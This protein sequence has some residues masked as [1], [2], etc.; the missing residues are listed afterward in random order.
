MMFATY[1]P[2]PTRAPATSLI[3]TITEHGVVVAIHC[4][5]EDA[6]SLGLTGTFERS[7]PLDAAIEPGQI[8]SVA[9]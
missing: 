4:D 6:P 3:A 8:V 7:Y 1:N 5:N 2:M 9:G